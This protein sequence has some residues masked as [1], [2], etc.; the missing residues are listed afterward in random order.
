MFLSGPTP[1][2]E[3]GTAGAKLKDFC[4]VPELLSELVEAGELQGIALSLLARK[5]AYCA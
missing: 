5:C 4:L 1:A 3:V 2:E